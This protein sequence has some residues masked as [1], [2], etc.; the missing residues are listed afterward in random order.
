M[1]RA[2]ASRAV[3]D[4][5]APAVSATRDSHRNLLHTAQRLPGRAMPHD[6][7]HWKTAYHYF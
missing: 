7:P 4:G 1:A 2:L 5:T 3:Q 6:L